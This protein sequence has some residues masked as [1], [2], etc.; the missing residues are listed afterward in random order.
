[1]RDITTAV[2]IKTT[3][4]A[5]TAN[6]LNSTQA[7]ELCGV[8]RTNMYHY[9]TNGEIPTRQLRHSRYATREAVQAFAKRFNAS[10]ITWKQDCVI[11]G[12]ITHHTPSKIFLLS[13]DGI[14]YKIN[15]HNY[16]LLSGIP[17][18][19]LGEGLQIIVSP[20]MVN[21]EK[22]INFTMLGDE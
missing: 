16:A 5:A 12:V 4:K 15:I 20:V 2:S 13:E 6:L 1:M 11:S 10:R 8:S 22:F 3:H 7:A 9:F 17:W 14:F 21:G 18:D 19:F